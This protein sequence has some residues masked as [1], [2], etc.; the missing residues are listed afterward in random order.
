MVLLL[1]DG[2][3]SKMAYADRRHDD[4]ADREEEEGGGGEETITAVECAAALHSPSTRIYTQS[5]VAVLRLH[6]SLTS[7]RMLERRSG[8]LWLT[9]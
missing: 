4:N 7:T 5:N 1:G 8:L 3:C 9:C 6:C 2:Y